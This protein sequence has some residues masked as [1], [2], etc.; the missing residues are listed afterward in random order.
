ML[1]NTTYKIVLRGWDASPT[2]NPPPSSVRLGIGQGIV[3]CKREHTLEYYNNTKRAAKTT[4]Y[5][6][7]LEER[8]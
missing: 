1:H 8:K 6:E 7:I 2:L 4:Y 3:V 5:V